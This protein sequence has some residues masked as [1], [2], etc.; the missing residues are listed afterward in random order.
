MPDIIFCNVVMS[1]ISH[2]IVQHLECEKVNKLTDLIQYSL[3]IH[4]YKRQLGTCIFNPW[5]IVPE[6]QW[7]RTFEYYIWND[8]RDKISYGMYYN[9]HW[10]T[11]IFIFKIAMRT[12]WKPLCMYM[13]SVYFR[14]FSNHIS[15][16]LCILLQLS[17][18]FCSLIPCNSTC[19]F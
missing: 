12:T 3:V 1:E 7:N 11:I 13:Y 19:I 15:C 17:Q 8:M 14:K 4:H 6:E 9:H 16:G 5:W 2:K 10:Q 18:L